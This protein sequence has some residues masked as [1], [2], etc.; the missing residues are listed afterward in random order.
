MTVIFM[1]IWVLEERY[2][3]DVCVDEAEWGGY[4]CQMDD[5]ELDGM[6]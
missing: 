2:P 5:E 1:M 6:E 4:G 3:F